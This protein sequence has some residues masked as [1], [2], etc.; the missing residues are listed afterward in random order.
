M[1]ISGKLES[2]GNE[3]VT[4]FSYLFFQMCTFFESQEKDNFIQ[5][6]TREIF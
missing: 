6:I 5:I 1:A 4:Y 2:S 3:G